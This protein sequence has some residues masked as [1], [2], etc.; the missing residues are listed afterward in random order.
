MASHERTGP[1]AYRGNAN[2]NAGICA[3]I[4][5]RSIVM[6]LLVLPLLGA[7]GRAVMRHR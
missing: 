3:F 6:L 2:M 1:F 7:V 4:R 5:F